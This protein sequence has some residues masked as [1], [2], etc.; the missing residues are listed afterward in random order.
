VDAEPAH[1]AKLGDLHEQVGDINAAAAFFHSCV[2]VD[3][4]DG[5]RDVARARLW[6]ARYLLA[7]GRTAEAEYALALMTML[8]TER[9]PLRYLSSKKARLFSR[10]LH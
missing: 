3:T 1:L 9:T 10:T 8:T 7:A 6:L 5:D 4:N 2:N